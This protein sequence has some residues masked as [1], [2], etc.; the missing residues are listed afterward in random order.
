MYFCITPTLS[1]KN[2]CVRGF[3]ARNGLC[4]SSFCVERE[5]GK[6]DRERGE[7]RE[8]LPPPPVPK[9]DG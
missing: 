2:L 1:V 8:A 5:R 9:V 7:R 6:R 4:E 3:D